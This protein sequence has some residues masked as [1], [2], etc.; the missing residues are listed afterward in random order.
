AGA[1]VLDLPTDRPRPAVQTYRGDALPAA[2]EPGL[3]AGLR[4][5]CR[6]QGITP[7]MALLAAFQVL[8]HRCSGQEDVTVGFPIAGRNR[9]EIEGLIGCFVNS[10]AVR[11]RLHGGVTLEAL[12]EEVRRETF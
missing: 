1:P 3:W 9:A 7:F 6:R 8:L 2:V 4:V 5:L 10:L 12:L 11:G